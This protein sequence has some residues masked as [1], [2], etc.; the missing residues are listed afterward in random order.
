MASQ[1]ATLSP[2]QFLEGHASVGQVLPHAQVVITDMAQN[3]LPSP[4]VGQIMIQAESQCL[5]YY[6][7]VWAP[8][9]GFLTD[10]LGYVSDRAHL[11]IVGRSSRKIISGGENIYPEPIEAAIWATGLVQDVYVLGVSDRDWGERVSAV[12]VPVDPGVSSFQL[13]ARVQDQCNPYQQP[14]DWIAVTALPRNLQGKIDVH[15]LRAWIE[16]HRLD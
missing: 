11:H 6:P 5:G 12:Y 16:S 15:R 13:A 9:T 4:Q 2:D 8:G 14:K 7:Q 10:D 3:P 1:V